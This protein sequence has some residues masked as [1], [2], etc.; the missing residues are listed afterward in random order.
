MF[1]V[2]VINNNVKKL[3]THL[4]VLN[5]DNLIVDG[6]FG[7]ITKRSVNIFQ[8]K[9]G[10]KTDGVLTVDEL[11]F[12]EE[13]MSQRFIVCIGAGHGGNDEDGNH[14][15]PIS[16]GKRYTHKGTL[17]HD[18]NGEFREGVE[19]R[20]VVD[21]VCKLL[22]EECIN[23]R[24]IHHDIYDTPLR[25]RIVEINR[26]KSAGFFGYLHSFH[27]N[28]AD[29]YVRDKN[30]K[31]IRKKTKSELDAIRGYSVFTT[32]GQNISDIIADE[33]FKLVNRA[34]PNWRM[35]PNTYIDGD[36]DWEADFYILR[37]TDLKK[38][39]PVFA[40]ILEEW[41]FYTS[42]PDSEFIMNSRDIR[43]KCAVDLA[44][45]VYK[46]MVKYDYV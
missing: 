19:N 20:I 6:H 27:S 16:N 15:T 31:P 40:A 3:Q 23:Y 7:N 32:R 36:L 8:E 12:L 37:N 39:S 17:M 28:A 25:Q 29:L 26:L 44:K 41:G 11:D 4:N 1:K 33:H 43:A 2:G 9:Y 14:M 42:E 45:K 22:D 18:G 30:N 13:V 38:A 46:L 5:E 24:K 34:L 35:R 10:F 21:K